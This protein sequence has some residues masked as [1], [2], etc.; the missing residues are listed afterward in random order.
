M[1]W[2]N[3]YGLI[4]IAI[5]MIPNSLFAIKNKNGFQDKW[6]NTYVEATEQIGRYGCFI[7]MIF[8]IPKTYFFPNF[9]KA[10]AIYLIINCILIAA[11]CSVWSVCF[12]KN[13]LFRALS[14]SVLPSI[15]FLFSGVMLRSIPLIVSALLFAPSHILIS[16]KNAKK[17]N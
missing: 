14:L 15:V 16:Y 9:D 12:N 5:I 1:G 4:M 6:H 3:Y 10:I 8:N 17:N 2:F 11:Y 7:F 13:T